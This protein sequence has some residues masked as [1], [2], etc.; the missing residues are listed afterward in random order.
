MAI[1]TEPQLDRPEIDGGGCAWT[2]ASREGFEVVRLRSQTDLE[3]GFAPSAGMTCCSLRADGDEL[4]ADRVG[5]EAYARDG[6]STCM[7]LMHP[8]ADRLSGWTYEACGRTVR[9][10]ISRRLHT[11]RWGLPVNGVHS[12][13]D[14]WQLEGKHAG[15][16]SAGLEATL[17]FD[18]DPERLALFPF[19][20]R[21]R[22]SAELSRRMLCLGFELEP[23]AGH[24]V[25]VC[26]GYRMYLRRS[27]GAGETVVLPARRRL[28]TDERLLPTGGWAAQEPGAYPVGLGERHEVFFLSGDRRVTVA[29]DERR[30]TVDL[31]EGFPLVH[32][33][34]AAKEPY[35]MIE[36][37]TAPPDALNHATF[38][39][40]TRGR[41]YRAALRLSVE[42][43]AGGRQF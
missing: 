40:A 22:L 15:A 29:T 2:H 33:R 41:P 6:I 5:L 24:A 26:F 43:R 7:S 38:P 32:V 1:A 12:C 30:I 9:L 27:N 20:H 11:D 17:R 16:E 23:S 39:L 42:A 10:P 3:A 36:A 21:L 34:T 13:G 8:W 19:P 25:P 37:L 4:L 35:V 28:A 14:A 18:S 31:L